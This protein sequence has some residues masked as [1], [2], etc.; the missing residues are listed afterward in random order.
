MKFILGKKIGMSQV[1][2]D[3]E[4]KREVIPVTLIEAGPCTITQI[5]TIEKDG[6]SGVQVGFLEK[7]KI[8][9]PLSGHLKDLGKCRYLKELRTEDDKEEY[10]AG[11]KVD[12]SV[13]EQGDAVSV[14]GVSKSKGFQGVMK[15]HN[16]KGGPAS[17]GQKHSNRKGGSIGCAFPEHV[18]KGKKMAGRMGGYQ[19]TQQ[20]L[21]IVEVDKE[22]NLLLVKGSVP[23][24]IGSLVKVSAI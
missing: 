24:S 9:K 13:F 11:D 18:I 19:V 7:K 17:H 8:N 16:F 6:Y 10:V 12:V 3:S 5:K 20:G 23:G 15:R 2:I 14:I 4:N 22:R 1:F 21:K